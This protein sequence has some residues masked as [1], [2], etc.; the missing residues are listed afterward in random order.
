MSRFAAFSD[1]RKAFDCTNRNTLFYKNVLYNY[2][3][4]YY[5]YYYYT[6]LMYNNICKYSN[7]FTVYIMVDISHVSN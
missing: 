5:Y 3:T 6:I 2:R 7:T 1:F 4:A